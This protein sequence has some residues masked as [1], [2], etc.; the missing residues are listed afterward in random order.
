MS[1]INQEPEASLGT[2]VRAYREETGFSQRQLAAMVG[3]HHSLLARIENGDVTQP[4]AELL[5]RLADTLEIDAQELLQ[6]IGV[7][8]VIPEPTM[9]FRREFGLSDA[10]AEEMVRFIKDKYKH[11]NQ[12]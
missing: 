12:E 2:V 7:R 4:S 11:R 3:M 10:E 5:Q 8:P 9:Y 6:F 1:D